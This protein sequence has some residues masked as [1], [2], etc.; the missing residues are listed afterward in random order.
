MAKKKV[1]IHTETAAKLFNVKPHEVTLEM[2]R[3]GKNAGFI[4]YGVGDSP[5][6]KVPAGILDDLAP[7]VKVHNFEHQRLGTSR[8]WGMKINL[9][10][11]PLVEPHEMDE[12]YQEIAAL[13]KRHARRLAIRHGLPQKAIT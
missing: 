2:R 8:H 4:R 1:D 6:S 9:V 3:I 7:V 13:I 10:V 12:V 11:D 5:L